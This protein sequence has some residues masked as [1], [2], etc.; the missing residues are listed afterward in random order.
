MKFPMVSSAVPA[1]TITA[2]YRSQRRLQGI[3]SVNQSTHPEASSKIPP[4]VVA[5]GRRHFVVLVANVV[6]ERVPPLLI[7]RN[8]VHLAGPQGEHVADR[9]EEDQADP[10]VQHPGK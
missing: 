6:V 10:R 7:H 1:C 5:A 2:I 8:K 4:G 9:N 3:D